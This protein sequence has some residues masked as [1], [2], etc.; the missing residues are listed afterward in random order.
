M[1]NQ[2]NT[3]GGYNFSKVIN[4]EEIIDASTT[5]NG[6]LIT[7]TGLPVGSIVQD[8]TIYISKAFGTL[9]ASQLIIRDQRGTDGFMANMS[10]PFTAG[11]TVY[12]NATVWNDDTTDNVI[13]SYIYTSAGTLYLAWVGADTVADLGQGELVVCANILS[14]SEYDTK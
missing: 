8:A 2:A 12:N 11:K 13:N 6:S 4:F 14:P 9:I 1:Y 7:L 3:L 5:A 10:S